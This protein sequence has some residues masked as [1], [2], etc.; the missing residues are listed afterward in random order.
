MKKPKSLRSLQPEQ[1]TLLVRSP[2]AWL[3]EEHQ[4]YFLL[5]LM[6]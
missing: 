5:D 3:A 1:S 6:D 2:R 4:V